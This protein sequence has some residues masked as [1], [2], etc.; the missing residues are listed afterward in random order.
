MPAACI[1]L[2]HGPG[3]LFGISHARLTKVAGERVSGLVKCL[4]AGGPFSKEGADPINAIIA[5][6]GRNI[7]Q[8]D[9]ADA[10]RMARTADQRGLPPREAPTSVTGWSNWVSSRSTSR[11]KAS[12]R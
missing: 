11:P 7:S 5:H 3:E 8:H 9:Q 4:E 2:P 1:I 10:F 6:I 12:S